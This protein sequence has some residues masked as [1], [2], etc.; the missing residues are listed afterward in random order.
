[1]STVKSLE[2]RPDNAESHSCYNYISLMG[3]PEDVEGRDMV[4]YLEQWLQTKVAP[5]IL[6]PGKNAQSTILPTTIMGA[7]PAGGGTSPQLQGDQI[8]EEKCSKMN[9]QVENS[10]VHIILDYTMAV[11][12][13]R[14]W[15]LGVERELREES[16]SYML[17]FQAQLKVMVNDRTHFFDTPSETWVWLEKYKNGT[18]EDLDR[19]APTPRGKHRR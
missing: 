7:A 13:K 11:E 4:A 12:K 10:R 5:S 8:I 16:I 6:L 1:M 15:F 14:S 2:K 9:L 19:G 18:A 3:L 17:L